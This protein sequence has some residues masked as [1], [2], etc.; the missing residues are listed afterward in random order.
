MAG[1][2]GCY[3]RVPST[4]PFDAE[5][6]PPSTPGPR[7][8]CSCHLWH[9]L[10]CESSADL[11]VTKVLAV[12]LDSCRPGSARRYRPRDRAGAARARGSLPRWTTTGV[13]CR[14]CCFREQAAWSIRALRAGRAVRTRRPVMGRERS[15]RSRR[16]LQVEAGA[17]VHRR[18]PSAWSG[19]DLFGGDSLLVGA[20]RR[21]V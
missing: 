11:G 9:E 16:G 20:G 17:G 1:A 19:D 2:R 15:V 3:P 12:S 18:C 6:R 13:R 10:E 8:T 14:Y 4:E 21:E 7:R 5:D